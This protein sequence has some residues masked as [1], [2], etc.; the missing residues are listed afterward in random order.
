MGT[1]QRWRCHIYRFNKN[2]LVPENMGSI[3][4]ERMSEIGARIIVLFDKVNKEYEGEY[5]ARLF[6]ERKTNN[7]FELLY[8]CADGV[9]YKLKE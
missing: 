6:N 3:L 4:P 5:V 8:E 1:M 9:V 7:E 2:Y